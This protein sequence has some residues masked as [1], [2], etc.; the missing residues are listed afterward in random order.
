MKFRSRL[1]VILLM[2]IVG[3]SFLAI[4]IT[5]KILNTS[6]IN[7]REE[8]RSFVQDISDFSKKKNPNFI[9]IPQNGHELITIDG[10]A[11][12]SLA[13]EYINSIDGIGRED[14][15]YGYDEDDEPTP[16]DI[17]R[18]MIEFLKVAKNQGISVLTTDYCYTISKMNDSYNK[19]SQEGFISF[20]ASHRNL[21][22]IPSYPPEPYN[23]NSGNVSSLEDAK[24][25]LY[26]INP[27][28]FLTKEE[29][30]DALLNSS[31][32]VLIIDLFF[33]GLQLSSSDVE[34]LKLKK[35]GGQRLVIAYM[36]IGEAESY[37]YYWKSEWKINPPQW[38]L[39]ENPNWPEN[40]KVK[41]WDS[42][43][44]D[45]I[46]WDD[47]SYLN[48]ILSAGFDGVYLDIID[49]FEYFEFF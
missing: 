1:Q 41:Y 35:N 20:A 8:M 14:L 3:I 18:E 49:A 44:Q 30:I 2:V 46:I 29:F 48:L 26:I 45:I 13:K 22:N 36:S 40:Y 17:S 9:I 27:S 32:D 7:Y 33:N 31:Y 21:D 19:N 6:N 25:F 34:L 12:G 5:V 38:L 10:I 47:N 28:S 4:G 11:N 16:P 23:L 37:R 15:F 24:N 43:W 39:N 42:K